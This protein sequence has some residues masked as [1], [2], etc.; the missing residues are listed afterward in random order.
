[1]GTQK[2]EKNRK[3]RQGKTGDGMANVKVKGENFYRSGK[4][5]KVLKR[6]TD[7]KAQRNAKGDITVRHFLLDCERLRHAPHFEYTCSNN[8]QRKQHRTKTEKRP[9]PALSPTGSGSTT[10]V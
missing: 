3:E 8:L 5:V 10:R 4:K 9:L 1:M 2:K 6:L 7:G